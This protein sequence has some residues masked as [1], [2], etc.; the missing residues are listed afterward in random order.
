ME[1]LAASI[2]GAESRTRDLAGKKAANAELNTE[3][4]DKAMR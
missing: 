1:T 2:V 3:D 4:T